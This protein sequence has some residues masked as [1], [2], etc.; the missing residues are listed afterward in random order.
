VVTV[1]AVLRTML[2]FQELAEPLDTKMHDG[3]H[4]PDTREVVVQVDLMLAV[5]REKAAQMRRENLPG[6]GPVN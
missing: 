3:Q 4:L 6:F 2:A 1:D 5:I